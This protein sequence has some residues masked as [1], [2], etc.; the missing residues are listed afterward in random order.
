MQ[1]CSWN[2]NILDL[3]VCP[4]SRFPPLTALSIYL[5]TYLS[6]IYQSVT[7]TYN[8][9]ISIIFQTRSMYLCVHMCVAILKIK[10]KTYLMTSFPLEYM[11]FF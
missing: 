11:L 8:L 3:I 4:E 6:S 10:C 7:F 2:P 9:I 5:S 1:A